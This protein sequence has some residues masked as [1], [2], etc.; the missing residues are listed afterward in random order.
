MLIRHAAAGK[1]LAGLRAGACAKCRA[2]RA[3]CAGCGVGVVQTR[4]L[5]VEVSFAKLG[6]QEEPDT[7]STAASVAE[8]EQSKISDVLERGV[9]RGGVPKAVSDT[10]V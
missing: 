4:F 10:P 3:S 8:P 7:L 2:G 1:M 9:P 6:S 5:V